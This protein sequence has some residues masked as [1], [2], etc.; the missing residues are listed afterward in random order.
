MRT[1]YYAGMGGVVPYMVDKEYFYEQSDESK[2]YAGSIMYW[3]DESHV[4]L[5]TYGDTVKIKYSQH[6]NVKLSEKKAVNVLYESDEVSA[7]FY[8]PSSTIME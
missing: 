7:T 1:G 5:V 4:A 3:N 6:S 2:V 8:M